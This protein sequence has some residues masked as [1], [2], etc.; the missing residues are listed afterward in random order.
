M[1]QIY[2]IGE[3]KVDTE[4]VTKLSTEEKVKMV[5]KL[6]DEGK[7]RD[8]IAECL[9]IK[10][11][12]INKMMNRNG[13][14]VEKGKFIEKDEDEKTIPKLNKP[15]LKTLKSIKPKL[16][17]CNTSVEQK[18][19]EVYNNCDIPVNQSY[20]DDSN[21]NDTVIVQNNKEVY[22]NCESD[23]LQVIDN[24]CDTSV[25]QKKMQEQLFA[26]L[27]LAENLEYLCNNIDKIKALI[28]VK[29]EK[30]IELTI[31]RKEEAEQTN[32]RVYKT[33]KQDFKKFCSEHSDYKVQELISQALKD[34][35]DKYK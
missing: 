32:Y 29:K 33:V 1:I 6:Q 28:D 7:E 26:I 16:N 13:F 21:K 22:N 3:I 10:K 30:Y 31:N 19:E 25:E 2:N 9:D 17:S 24:N 4:E 18:K 5:L 15:K 12:S 34:F 23:V 20:S 27:P 14:K 8:E 11:D 35:M